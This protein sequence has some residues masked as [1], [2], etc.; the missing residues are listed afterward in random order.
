MSQTNSDIM[1][2]RKALALTAAG[3]TA[4]PALA[5]A[6]SFEPDPIYAAIERCRVAKIAAEDACIAANRLEESLPDETTRKP[7]VHLGDVPKFETT[8]EQDAE[9]ALTIRHKLSATARTPVFADSIEDIKHNASMAPKAQREAWIKEKLAALKADEEMLHEAQATA[10][11]IAAQE[12][13]DA[14]STEE[15]DAVW[16]LAN[17]VPSTVAGLAAVMAYVREFADK[18]KYEELFSGEDYASAF[19]FSIEQAVC[20]LAGLPAPD[21]PVSLELVA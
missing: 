21:L 11:L 12:A 8:A 1:S 15:R 5:Q 20:V 17:T 16:E 3:L 14:A 4:A 13:E 2:R 6:A 9:G 18:H 10:G 7:R 19:H